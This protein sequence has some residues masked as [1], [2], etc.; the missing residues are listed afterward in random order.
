VGLRRSAP[1]TSL[2]DYT[3]AIPAARRPFEALSRSRPHPVPGSPFQRSL[4]TPSAARLRHW[5][6]VAEGVLVLVGVY[7]LIGAGIGEAA[8]SVLVGAAAGLISGVCALAAILLISGSAV[9]ARGAADRG[10]RRAPQGA[11]SGAQPESEV[12][13]F[14]AA[15]DPMV[16]TAETNR[17]RPSNE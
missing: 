16:A 4:G 8:G 17:I 5:L 2:P 1:P 9:A 15:A 14:G 6:S 11:S 12:N 7:I 13:I 3:L 10:P